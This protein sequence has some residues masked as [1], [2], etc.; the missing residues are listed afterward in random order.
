MSKPR[1]NKKA[2]IF[3]DDLPRGI[4]LVFAVC[5]FVL[6][7]SSALTLLFFWNEATDP[8]FPERPH[9]FV[10]FSQFHYYGIPEHDD[11]D[12]HAWKTLPTIIMSNI[13]QKF[14][15]VEYRSIML[16]QSFWFAGII[17]MLSLIA[18]RVAGSA[19]A[20]FT[21]GFAAFMPGLLAVSAAYDDHA[22]NLFAATAAVYFL[23]RSDNL[24]RYRFTAAA[25]LC[26]GVVMRHA[27]RPTV[28]IMAFASALSAVGGLALE[29]LLKEKKSPVAAGSKGLNLK[30][31]WIIGIL[32]FLA[33]ALM[34]GLRQGIGG[35]IVEVSGEVGLTPERYHP[36]E[37]YSFF[38][39]S[40]LLAR[41]LLGPV[42]L[43]A[44]ALGL[45]GLFYNKVP[46]RM[47]LL[48]WFL[49]LNIVLSFIPRKNDFYIFYVM[50]AAAPVAGVGIASFK[51]QWAYFPGVLLIAL[52]ALY[53]THCMTVKPII[54]KDAKVF[55]YLDLN[56]R[57]YL[58]P[59]YREVKAFR[60]Q[61]EEVVRA[62]CRLEGRREIQ[63]I[64]MGSG[65]MSDQ[66]MYY[67]KLM[68]PQIRLV[69]LMRAAKLPKLDENTYLLKSNLGPVEWAME[70]DELFMESLQTRTNFLRRNGEYPERKADEK[71]MEGYPALLKNFRPAFNSQAFTLYRRYDSDANVLTKPPY[72][73]IKKANDLFGAN[74]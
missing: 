4:V 39:Y 35:H 36:Y 20:I 33:C 53:S 11:W 2:R 43:V 18:F 50:T 68:A 72:E 41:I 61:V 3:S 67:F 71:I 52:S 49:G 25:G 54:D 65:H 31:P 12:P 22:F 58:K 47:T 37:P 26:I 21:A 27:F 23:I 1:A 44:F 13:F 64:V 60:G 57:F 38:V 14:F 59:P 6:I 40:I 74:L 73:P 7:L 45:T 5:L 24:S 55:D 9:T 69:G 17:I 30:L 16:S 10:A 19:A 34:I 32:I 66:H 15:G 29:N 56:N 42:V 62:V 48:A 46:H 51:K 8:I 28:G 63:L 70:P